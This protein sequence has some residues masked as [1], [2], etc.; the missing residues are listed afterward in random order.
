MRRP[1]PQVHAQRSLDAGGPRAAGCLDPAR[2][3]APAASEGLIPEPQLDDAVHKRSPRHLRAPREDGLEVV[4]VE[5]QVPDER[6]DRDVLAA[7]H[8]RELLV[9]LEEGV[10]P[11][12]ELLRVAHVPHVQE[13]DG[14]NVGRIAVADQVVYV[15]VVELHGEQAVQQAEGGGRPARVAAH[16]RLHVVNFVVDLVHQ[17]HEVL[18]LGELHEVIR[19]QDVGAQDP[20]HVVGFA[21]VATRARD[22]YEGGHVAGG[23]RV[24]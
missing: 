13:P 23:L 19:I 5:D 21:V 24:A 15:A 20:L 17:V 16:P 4:L 18:D 12:P 11:S 22:G 7:G 3:A 1:L 14:A 8:R 2:S 6:A 10:E 9:V